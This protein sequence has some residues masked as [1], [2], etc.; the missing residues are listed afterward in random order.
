MCPQISDL[1][2]DPGPVRLRSLRDDGLRPADVPR[3]PAR[4]RCRSPFRRG[5]A[6]CRRAARRGRSTRSGPHRGSCLPAGLAVVAAE[7]DREVLALAP[8]G[9]DFLAGGIAPRG[10][11][12]RPPPAG[13]RPFIAGLIVSPCGETKHTTARAGPHRAV[14][15]IGGSRCRSVGEAGL[16][17]SRFPVARLTNSRSLA[18]EETIRRASTSSSVNRASR[19]SRSLSRL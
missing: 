17:Y 14:G 5:R 19:I 15:M 16:S 11:H 18:F 13:R 10:G 8:A 3:E 7:L 9:G 1:P 4:H 6:R 2:R 12:T